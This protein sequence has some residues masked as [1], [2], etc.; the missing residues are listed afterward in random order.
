[1]AQVKN[2][3]NASPNAVPTTP[4]LDGELLLNTGTPAIYSR[5]ADGS[6]ALF[7]PPAS[8]HGAGGA[9]HA[10]ATQTA[11]GFMSAADKKLWDRLS[12]CPPIAWWSGYDELL[13]ASA[14][15]TN[16]TFSNAGGALRLTATSI[17]PTYRLKTL[18]RGDR[19]RY[20]AVRL[21]CTNVTAWDGVIF[22]G[23]TSHTFGSYNVQIDQPSGTD[24]ALL[25]VDMWSLAS[26]G[27]DWATS[28]INALRFDFARSTG[29]VVDIAWVALL[30]DTMA[31]AS[32][33]VSQARLNERLIALCRS[34]ITI[35]TSS[36]TIVDVNDRAVVRLDKG[37]AASGSGASSSLDG[38]RE[39]VEPG[40]SVVARVR[41]VAA[42]ASAAGVSLTLNF[43]ATA[44]ASSPLSS[45]TLGITS[46]T[47]SEVE[48]SLPTTVPAGARYAS[49]TVAL[50][51]SASTQTI[52]VINL[53]IDTS[54]AA[55]VDRMAVVVAGL[56][57]A[58]I[59][60]A[61]DAVADGGQIIVP[62]GTYA[63]P[64]GLT[65]ASNKR[66][67]WTVLGT[68][69]AEASTNWADVLPGGMVTRPGQRTA[70]T[71][72]PKTYAGYTDLTVPAGLGLN[73]IDVSRWY[74]RDYGQLPTSGAVQGR[75]NGWHLIDDVQAGAYGIRQIITGE[76]NV[77]GQPDQTVGGGNYV[78]VAGLGQAL[79]PASTG[80]ERDAIFGANFYGHLTNAA[81]GW[82]NA[83]GLEADINTDAAVE[84][85]SAVQIAGLG[86]SRGTTVDAAFWGEYW[87]SGQSWKVGFQMGGFSP[88]AAIG[89][90]GTFA[91]CNVPTG[92]ATGLDFSNTPISG[93][94][95]KSPT[96]NLKPGRAEFTSAGQE[97][98]IGNPT[99]ASTVQQL[100]YSSGHGVGVPDATLYVTGGT[101]AAN[102]GTVV[103]NSG[104][105]V[106]YG[107]IRPATD[108]GKDLG[109]GSYRW[110][111]LFVGNAPTVGSDARIKLWLGEFTDEELD[112]VDEIGLGTYQL[113]AS[114]ALKGDEA[115]LHAGAIAQ[116][117]QAAFAAHGLDARRRGLWCEDPVI[118]T[119]EETYE[120]EAAAVETYL[121]D[122]EVISVVDG[123]AVVKIESVERT[124]PVMI[125]IPVL[126]GDGNVVMAPGRPGKPG[127]PAEPERR[128][129]DEETGDVKVIPAV[130]ERPEIPAVPPMPRVHHVPVT[131]VETR[132]RRVER[133]AVD[134]DGIPLTRL[135]LRYEQLLV[136]L[137]AADRR[138]IA[139][140]AARV[141]ALEAAA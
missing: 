33:P 64:S 101:S 25:L 39:P 110:N 78:G 3:T 95:L 11:A 119:V 43:W 134:A 32:R 113:L 111:D 50:G 31:I 73:A 26:G 102:E 96:I 6:V 92:I 9:V 139:R 56:T 105:L 49:A 1:M 85:R 2:K 103:V 82:L 130:A 7:A 66:I 141:A 128:L 48:Y 38:W 93:S 21:R 55:S 117:V 91:V 14:G 19:V 89:T 57:S 12:Q 54:P 52:D 67:T 62:P 86:A 94:V 140:L 59:Q 13:D 109:T 71:G 36:A 22:Y 136:M 20:I 90:D 23:T 77:V 137:V 131:T 126:D 53:R 83:C 129:V 104:E 133:Q 114:R 84:L 24:W 17:D 65:N 34:S 80:A 72:I 70:T 118:E 97:I 76:C 15:S 123:A 60:A 29:D 5:K 122:V 28:L 45:V 107:G 135:S 108:N 125:E 47:T 98:V 124:R 115:R 61:I 120:V 40:R 116:Q 138:K 44:G 8:H 75:F 74:V 18:V 69:S 127:R 79:A 100:F 46:V 35:G 58:D 37:S 30:G 42:A 112:A 4:P 81:T 87:T 132:T 27:T 121:E 68:L 51:T 88:Y 99:T 63:T 41:F 10:E 16:V 106:S